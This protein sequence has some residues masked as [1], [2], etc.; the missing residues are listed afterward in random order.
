MIVRLFMLLQGTGIPRY[1][2]VVMA[3]EPL[4]VRANV[5]KK[6]ESAGLARNCADCPV[7]TRSCFVR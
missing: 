4:G 6:L 5:E 7:R 2:H 1:N 3:T